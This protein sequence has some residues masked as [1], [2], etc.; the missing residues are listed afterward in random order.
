MV[1][2]Y[3]NM[4][5]ESFFEQ[6]PERAEVAVG[7]N[8]KTHKGDKGMV[9]YDHYFVLTHLRPAGNN[10]A[11]PPDIIERC[12]VPFHLGLL[13]LGIDEYEDKR[14]EEARER[15][16]KRIEELAKAKNVF[17]SEGEWAWH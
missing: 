10:A 5:L 13:S 2:V 6:L 7:R 14:F 8:W 3:R 15:T 16:Y 17:L 4:A 9:L 1:K 12:M 11:R